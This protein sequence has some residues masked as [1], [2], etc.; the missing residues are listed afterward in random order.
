MDLGGLARFHKGAAKPFV[1]MIDETRPEE[2][3]LEVA[4]K[5][6]GDEDV[7]IATKL[8]NCYRIDVADVP[9][10]E[11]AKKY[12]RR[13][14][15]LYFFDQKG[16]E[17]D[18][19]AGK[20]KPN[21]VFRRLEKAFDAFYVGKLESWVETYADALD[22]LQKAED[23]VADANR[24]LEP[25]VERIAKS[26]DPKKSLLEDL[27]EAEKKVLAK[28]KALEDARTQLAKLEKH[29]R[30]VDAEAK[31]KAEAAASR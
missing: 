31:A 4:T 13:V 3:R 27:D 16:N 30:I 9:E 25:I 19:L 26:G 28:K 18:G 29:E 2:D 17:I 20:P 6:F 12:G 8:F 7:V 22:V 1:V 11:L 21:H 23:E 5:I 24:F 10:G 15:A 14:P